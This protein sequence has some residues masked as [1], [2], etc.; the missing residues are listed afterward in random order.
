[1]LLL[2]CNAAAQNVT[3]W[4]NDNNRTGWQQNE[5]TLTPSALTNPTCATA[6]CFGLLWQYTGLSGA[7]YAQ[8]L[9]YTTSS[10]SNI[11]SCPAPCTAVFIATE[12]DMLYAFNANS[13]S[14]TPLWSLDLAGA[15][16]AG[17][18]WL[19]CANNPPT[20][21]ICAK[22]VIYPDIGV[23]S[24]PVIDPNTNT[25]YVVSVVVQGSA[26]NYYLHA[27]DVLTGSDQNPVAIAGEVPGPIPSSVDFCGAG[28]GSGEDVF[29]PQEHYQR[30]GLLL[31]QPPDRDYDGIYVA[32]S[33]GGPEYDNGWIF[34]Y[35]YSASAGFSQ[36]AI[37]STTPYGSGGGIWGSGG[38][39]A[40]AKNSDGNTYVYATTGNGTF[41]ASNLV[42]PNTDYGDSAV[43]LDAYNFHV[44]GYFTPS[45]QAARCADD[46][47]FGSGGILMLPDSGYAGYPDLMINAEKEGKFFVLDRDNLGGYS[48]TDSGVVEEVF[49]PTGMMWANWGG[50]WS[51]PA[52]WKW[53]NSQSGTSRSL[54]YSVR[55]NQTSQPP[56]PITMYTLGSVAPLISNP[57]TSSTY[58]GFCAYGATPS[59]SSDGATGGILWA[60]EAV[61]INNP[62]GAGSG[63]CTAG[64]N[65]PGT[66]Y[67]YLALHAYDATNLDNQ[68]YGPT[69]ELYSGRGQNRNHPTGYPRKFITPTISNGKVFVG[70]T[71]DTT[72]TVGMVDVYGL[73]T[74]GTNGQCL[75]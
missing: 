4:H 17:D 8:P 62:Q 7:I 64:Q 23:T 48:P 37:F 58:E 31:L 28:S 13:S 16:L 20:N 49:P 67:T 9:V 1:M 51:A 12:R 26:I 36:A 5:T 11:G 73:C 71:S 6:G 56:L 32:F 43:Q 53:T 72:V 18:T 3:T 54:F 59:V 66:N 50:F 35:E 46:T 19:N 40:A 70:A 52:Y 68:S 57:P 29:T 55:G 65:E 34:T 2:T 33:P 39:L 69:G 45:D 41:D 14:N 15:V 22:G 25:L 21:K 24:T 47:D 44:Y 75:N 10:G 61:N 30:A 60:I 42:P 27:V 74:S 63:N 38:G